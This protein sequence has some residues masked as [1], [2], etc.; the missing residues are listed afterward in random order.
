M[1]GSVTQSFW[2]SMDSVLSDPALEPSFATDWTQWAGA[3]IGAC[4]VG[5]TGVL[6]LWVI[7]AKALGTAPSAPTE[8]N[9]K[10][11]LAFAVGGLLGDVFLHLLPETYQHMIDS[12]DVDGAGRIGT[13]VL[14]GI[15]TFLVLE[16]V[17]EISNPESNQEL[18]DKE[19]KKIVGYLNLLANCTDNL[20]HGL[21]VGTSFLSSFRLGVTT[22]A[23][24]LLHEIPHEFGD[25]AILLKSG[26]DRWE[27][28]KA[29]M[30]TAL[31]GLMG[32][33]LALAC[34]TS[35]GLET[36]LMYILPFTAGGF[37]NIALVSLVPELMEETRPGPALAQFCCVVGGIVAMSLLTM[38]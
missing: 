3:I 21:A 5:L 29:Q 12:G 34:D 4:L 23:A 15:L 37:L 27:A 13:A 1:G 32:A 18:R 24:I 8:D 14:T 22:T 28:A 25:F 35:Q 2:I 7:P 38:I 26:F 30:S 36:L 31:V 19:N 17:L 9:L 6:P 11:L 33:L 20:L 16:K 10:Y